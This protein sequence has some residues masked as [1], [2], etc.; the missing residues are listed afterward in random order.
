MLSDDMVDLI[1]RIQACSVCGIIL[2]LN[3]IL[4]PLNPSLRLFLIMHH[5]RPLQS[6]ELPTNA[7]DEEYIPFFTSIPMLHP[8]SSAPEPKRRFVP[9]KWEHQKIMKIVRSIRKVG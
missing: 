2:P 4:V 5:F 1:Q 7:E 8:I 9:S 3:V 6:G